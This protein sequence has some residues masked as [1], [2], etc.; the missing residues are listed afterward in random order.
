MGLQLSDNLA[1]KPPQENGIEVFCYFVDEE[2]GA[3]LGD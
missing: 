2:V 3:I 1:T